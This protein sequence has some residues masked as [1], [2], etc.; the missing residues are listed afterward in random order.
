MLLGG[1]IAY[2]NRIKQEL[3]EVPSDLLDR[4]G[5]V[6]AAVAK[7]MAEGVRRQLGSDWGIAVTGV[8]GPGGG[9]ESKPVGL[10]H[11]A[12]A[13]PNGTNHLERR[14]G[15]RRAREWIRGLSVGDALNLLRLRL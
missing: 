9:S 4:E 13:G 1:V 7:A 15:N 11:F 6:S 8:A 14:Y 10:V 12:V 2:A 5:A 3:L